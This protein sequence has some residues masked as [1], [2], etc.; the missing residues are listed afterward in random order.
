M[1]KQFT[2]GRVTPHARRVGRKPCDIRVGDMQLSRSATKHDHFPLSGCDYLLWPYAVPPPPP[3][4]H[5]PSNYGVLRERKKKSR[6]VKARR[7][8][9]DGALMHPHHWIAMKAPSSA[10]VNE[11]R[12][13]ALL[14][15]G[16]CPAP[17][18]LVGCIQHGGAGARILSRPTV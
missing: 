3:A 16:E 1:A 18:F 14:R 13:S 12:G 8:R 5:P 15:R 7:R 11:K 6:D 17:S 2:R 10:F 9:C 4:L